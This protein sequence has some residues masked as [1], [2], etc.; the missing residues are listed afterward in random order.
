MPCPTK[1]VE[2][3]KIHMQNMIFHLSF[4]LEQ[5]NDVFVIY[6]VLAALIKEFMRTPCSRYFKAMCELFGNSQYL[7]AIF[8]A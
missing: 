6:E 1:G 5:K 2:G 4:Q 8:Y 7:L 3:T